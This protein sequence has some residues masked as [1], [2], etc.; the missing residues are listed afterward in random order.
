MR[1]GDSQLRQRITQEAARLMYEEGVKEYFTAKRMAAKRVLGKRAGGKQNRSPGGLPSNGEIQAALLYL[2]EL[3]EGESRTKRLALMRLAALEAMRCLA[4]FSP[5]L[6]GS[7]GTGHVRC[8]SDI[9]IQ[10]FDDDP[11]ELR[12]HLYTL[13]WRYE[14][15]NVSILKSGEVREYL[16][17]Y[18]DDVFAI[19]LTIYDRREL[20]VV[21]RS[22]TDGQPIRRLK[23]GELEAL[24]ECEHPDEL[25]DFL[26]FG[27]HSMMTELDAPTASPPGPFQSLVSD[28]KPS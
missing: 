24:I 19:E 2:A 7:V 17:F 13:G 6:I 26:H 5:R 18:I 1:R 14:E 11:D 27:L 28:A 23:L 15:K 10:V 12:S 21:P 9:D 4:D 22:S 8:G 20:R 3:A 16:H 25:Q